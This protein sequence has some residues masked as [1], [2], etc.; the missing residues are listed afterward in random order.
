MSKATIVRT[1]TQMAVSVGFQNLTRQAIAERLDIFPSSISFHCKSM[2][3]LRTLMVGFAIENA[4]KP[5]RF[6]YID[7]VAQ[8]LAAR[9]PLALRAPAKV[10][11]EAAKLLTA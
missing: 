3:N 6:H 10:K 4:L 11:A 1:A 7:V 9:H 8:A 2:D 5:G